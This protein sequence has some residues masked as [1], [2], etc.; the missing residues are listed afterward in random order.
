MVL[1]VHSCSVKT[2]RFYSQSWVW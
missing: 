2:Q 1:Q